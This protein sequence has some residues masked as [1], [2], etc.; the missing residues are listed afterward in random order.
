MIDSLGQPV[1]GVIVTLMDDVGAATAVSSTDDDGH[2]WIRAQAPAS[3][4][5]VTMHRDYET[6]T[7]SAFILEDQEVVSIT[8][9]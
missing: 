1:R 7:S 9:R 6:R 4:R 2:Y 5:I 8:L 3:Y